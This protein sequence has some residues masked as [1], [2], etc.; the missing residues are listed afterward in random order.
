MIRL[1]TD[2]D[3]NIAGIEVITNLL[4]RKDTIQEEVRVLK[5]NLK[6]RE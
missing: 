3:V 6:V 2:L 4:H 1:H 5:N